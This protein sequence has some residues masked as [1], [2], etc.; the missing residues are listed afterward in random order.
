MDRLIADVKVSIAQQIDLS[1]RQGYWYLVNKPEELLTEKT[2]YPVYL[3]RGEKLFV[4]ITTEKPAD[5]R[6]YN[7]KSHQLM[8]SYIGK[9]RVKDSLAISFSYVYV[10]EINPRIRQYASIE[11]TYHPNSIDRLSHPKQVTTKQVKVKKET[12]GCIPPKESR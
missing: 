11:L 8:R 3:E 5:I 9:S 6:I 1:V 10:V 12:S 2:E 4:D 7:V